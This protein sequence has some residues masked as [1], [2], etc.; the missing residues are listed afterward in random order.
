MNSRAARANHRFVIA[1]HLIAS[2]EGAKT[3]KE[4][5]LALLHCPA[6]DTISKEDLPLTE[7][8]RQALW[9]LARP[10][11]TQQRADLA[12]TQGRDIGTWLDLHWLPIVPTWELEVVRAWGELADTPLPDMDV[13]P[14]TAA[15]MEV[16]YC[17]YAQNEDYDEEVDR[18]LHLE[19]RR[20]A[21]ELTRLRSRSKQQE[22][23]HPKVD[24]LDPVWWHGGQ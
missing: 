17:M 23:P 5:F 24:Y 14:V 12:K 4:A 13:L 1:S 2:R 19:L 6:L 11:V 18:Q 15:S 22:N 9:D 21:T 10:F 20:I 7:A 3:N 16:V 8:S